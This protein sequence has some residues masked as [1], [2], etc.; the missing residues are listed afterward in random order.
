MSSDNVWAL[1]ILKKSSKAVFLRRVLG[2]NVYYFA[3]N[4]AAR[5][6]LRARKFKEQ[7]GLE[8]SLELNAFS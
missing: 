6:V 7:N 3:A 4:R 1:D 2:E 5:R 8:I